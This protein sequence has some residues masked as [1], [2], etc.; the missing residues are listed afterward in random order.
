MR[1]IKQKRGFTL[2]ELLIVVAIIGVLVAIAIPIFS[3]QLEKS[4]ESTDLANVR[5]AYAE[6]MAAA[7]TEDDQTGIKQADGTYQ[8]TVS[9]R[10]KVEDWTIGG[11]LEIG[12]VPSTD[13]AHWIGI[14]AAGGSCTVIYDP[15]QD[16][17]TI[18]W[19]GSG[20]TTPGG[21]GSGGDGSGGGTPGGSTP[22]GSTSIPAATQT[23]IQTAILNLLGPVDKSVKL[24]INVNNGDIEVNAQG[25]KDNVIPAKDKIIEA[26]SGIDGVTFQDGKM[27][28]NGQPA[29][30]K[31]VVHANHGDSNNGNGGNGN[32]NGGNH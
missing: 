22:S 12:G 9:L 19:S 14:P 30:G 27:F 4:R 13:T 5:A 16:A 17:V 25:N 28:I 26:L 24:T 6:V 1:Q 7:I 11:T 8:M 29:T 2:A 18:N 15:L 10:Q 3:S 23:S 21:D 31:I 20:G 32:G